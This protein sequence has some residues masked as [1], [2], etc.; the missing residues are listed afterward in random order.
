[1]ISINARHEQPLQL[2]KCMLD[3]VKEH[4]AANPTY[5]FVISK[6]EEPDKTLSGWRLK[7]NNLWYYQDGFCY[8]IRILT[9]K[10]IHYKD[11]LQA[12]GFDFRAVSPI[13]TLPINCSE[14][15]LVPFEAKAYDTLYELNKSFEASKKNTSSL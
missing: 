4:E 8:G 15:E 3:W 11:I 1:M 10:R 14:K 5:T 13:D 7:V 6:N 9:G 12:T 2:P